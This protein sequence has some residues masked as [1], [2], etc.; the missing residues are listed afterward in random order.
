MLRVFFLSHARCFHLSQNQSAPS[1]RRRCWQWGVSRTLWVEL[2]NLNSALSLG[3]GLE[4]SLPC[5]SLSDNLRSLASD[6]IQPSPGIHG[7]LRVL[8]S[9]L[10]PANKT[11][12]NLRWDH[13]NI[14]YYLTHVFQHLPAIC[15][16]RRPAGL[17]GWFEARPDPAR[18]AAPENQRLLVM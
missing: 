8:V 2:C 16:G 13:N 7:I 5:R 15:R 17:A 10:A 9:P 12:H 6:Q 1:L 3:H 18:A 14:G 11:W 4:G